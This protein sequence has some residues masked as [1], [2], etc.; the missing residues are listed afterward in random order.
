MPSALASKQKQYP[1]TPLVVGNSLVQ[2]I[3]KEVTAALRILSQT[4]RFRERNAANSI[5]I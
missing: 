5:Y 2:P 4:N 1:F 3:N